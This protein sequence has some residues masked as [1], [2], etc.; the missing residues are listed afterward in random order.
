MSGAFVTTIIFIALSTALAAFVRRR[1]RDK[2]LKDFSADLTTLER[3]DGKILWGE[4]NVENTGLEFVYPEKHKDED[5]HYETSFILYKYE[6]PKITVLIRYH[7]ELSEL[8]KKERAEEL[9]RTYHPTASKKLK[10]F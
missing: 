6:Y 7:D 10:N 5:G 4:L 3:T 2:C 9:Q 1:K 8:G